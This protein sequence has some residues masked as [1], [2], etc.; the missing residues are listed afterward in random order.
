MSDPVILVVDA[1]PDARRGVE[2]ELR[3]RYHRHYRIE[4][5]D[6]VDAARQLLADLAG[7]HEVA[8]VLA[9]QPLHSPNGSELFDDVR[10]LHPRARIAVLIEWGE[11]G[12]PATGHAI[13]EAIARGRVDHYV[14]RS[15]SPPDEFFHHEISGLLLDWADAQRESPYTI[16]VVGESWSGRAYEL[17]EMLGR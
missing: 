3:D 14:L 5:L 8:L 10:R 1:D 16:V 7:R 9:G 12:D 2:R 15:A 17:R 11:R 4:C 6:S 13:F